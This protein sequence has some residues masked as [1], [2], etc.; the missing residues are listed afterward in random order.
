MSSVLDRAKAHF[1]SGR[2]G[3][4]DVAEWNCKI[5]F[6]RPNLGEHI[7]F[8][9]ENE[10]DRKHALVTLV[11]ERSLDEK[12]ERIFG[13]GAKVYSELAGSVDPHILNRIAQAIMSPVTEQTQGEIEK[14]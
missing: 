14:N 1:D 5:H 4:I 12:G 6:T 13:E 7:A 3:S 2:K 10:K 8:N 9:A 11:Q